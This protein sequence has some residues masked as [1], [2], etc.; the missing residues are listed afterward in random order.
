MTVRTTA[1][2]VFSLFLI[3]SLISWYWYVC[4]IRGFCFEFN[5][6]SVMLVAVS[7][8]GRPF[9]ETTYVD[10][11]KICEKMYISGPIGVNYRNHFAEVKRLEH[12]LNITQSE[13]LAEDG[14]FGLS[15]TRALQRFQWKY[16]DVI[17]FPNNL[18]Y[19][20]GRIDT[21][22]LEYINSVACNAGLVD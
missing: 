14:L 5:N 21:H 13:D 10:D 2:I 17:L 16:R 22:T 18:I 8:T 7:H 6:P 20:S 4:G 1:I 15:D 11:G 12:F 9:I 3:W 19:P